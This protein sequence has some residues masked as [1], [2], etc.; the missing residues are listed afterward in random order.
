MTNFIINLKATRYKILLEILYD[1]GVE[2]KKIYTIKKRCVFMGIPYWKY[3]WNSNFK[4]LNF[5]SLD[6]ARTHI[7]NLESLNKKSGWIKIP[8]DQMRFDK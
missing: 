7:R 4:S 6:K 3:L 2:V 5:G 1:E 8:L